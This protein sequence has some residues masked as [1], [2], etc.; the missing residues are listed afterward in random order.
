[1]NCERLELY[2]KSTK[3][4]ELQFKKDGAGIDITDWTIYFTV[5]ENMGDTDGNAKIV[6]TITSHSAATSGK[7]LIEW[8]S[9]DTDSPAGNYYYSID[10]KDDD[11]NEDILLMGRIRIIEPIL[12]TRS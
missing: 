4:Y 3:T 12:Q 11:D 6:K 2:R 10:Y 7:T 8:A 5:K 9:S 1:M